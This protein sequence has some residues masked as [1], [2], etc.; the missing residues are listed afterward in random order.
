M[1]SKKKTIKAVCGSCG[2]SG[3]Y[4]GFCEA[5]GHP[6]VCLSCN[7]TGC[8]EIQYEPFEKRRVIRGV[9]SVRLSRGSFI[10]TGVGGEG[11]S[12]TYKEFLEGTLKYGR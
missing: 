11:K 4:Q 1:P 9:K 7:G 10:G 6:V 8:E 12:V 5:K 2:G 3:L